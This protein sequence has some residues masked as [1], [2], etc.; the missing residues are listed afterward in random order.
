MVTEVFADIYRMEI[1]LPRNPLRAINSYLV[2]GGDRW[3][4]IDT[5][6]NRSE[7]LEVMRAALNALAIDLHRTDFFITHCHSDHIG[8][9]SALKTEAS[10]VFLHPRDAALILNPNLW[11]ELAGAARAH[12]FPDP[13]TAVE[14]HPGRRYLF[15]GHPAFAARR[16]GDPLPIGQYAFRCV[17]TPG[18]TPGHMCLY[19]PEARILFAGDHI[20]D[21]I[22]PNISGWD[23]QADP[24][25]AFLKSLDKIA[26]YDVRTILPGHRHL[27][28][29]PLRR[30]GELKEHHRVRL[31]EVLTLLARED[32]T[33][34]QVASR[35]TWNINY[36]R[37]GE[38]PV[39]Q[40]WFATGEA[41][42][43]LLHLEQTGRIKRHWEEGKARF[44]LSG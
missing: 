7:C 18:H 5:G 34:Y 19:E 6:M 41:L 14:Q 35:M 40:Q 32:Q 38:F 1:P 10:Q 22:T 16:E 25:G 29:D 28:P 23:G 31:Q 26:A 33:A 3:L 24:L 20:L 9:V 30:I 17:E 37:W 11:G 43:H 42:S 2:R 13:D 12:G 15:R 8:L 27:I 36:A 21:P 44:S 4:V 39:S